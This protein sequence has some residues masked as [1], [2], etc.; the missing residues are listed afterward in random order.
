MTIGQLIECLQ[1]KVSAI[2]G[3]EDDTTAFRFDIT[4]EKISKEFH[5]LGYQLRG[6]ETMYSG[7]TSR[8]LEGRSKKK[9]FISLFFFWINFIFKLK[10]FWDLLTINVLNIWWTTKLIVWHAITKY[11]Q[12]QDGNLLVMLPQ[13]TMLATLKDGKLVY[14][15]PIKVLHFS[16]YKGKM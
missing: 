7:L 1:G 10:Y 14:E 3:N 15:K 4:V 2:N 5:N 13:M 11:L 8:K 16:N 9:I 6:N 12:H